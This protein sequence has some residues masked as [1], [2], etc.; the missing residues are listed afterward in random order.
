MLSFTKF[1]KDVSP[2]YKDNLAKQIESKKKNTAYASSSIKT[3]SVILEYA[4]KL[5]PIL[6]K[7]YERYFLMKTE[8]S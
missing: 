1:N 2:F 4:S 7:I 5:T 6:K 8:N 3:D